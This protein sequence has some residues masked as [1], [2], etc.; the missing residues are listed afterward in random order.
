R[1]RKMHPVLWDSRTG[2]LY[3]GA[4]S[5]AVLDRLLPLFRETFDRTLEPITAGVLASSIAAEM[6]RDDALYDSVPLALFGDGDSALYS[7][8]AWAEADPTSRDYWGNEFLLW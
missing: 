7:S 4:S 3:A 8:I 5:N 1:R 6:G 2:I